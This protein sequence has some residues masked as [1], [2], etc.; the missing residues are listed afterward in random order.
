MV[1]GG[2][3]IS[4]GGIVISTGGIVTPTSTAMLVAV[5]VSQANPSVK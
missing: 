3:V 5:A 2:I 1:T 4:T